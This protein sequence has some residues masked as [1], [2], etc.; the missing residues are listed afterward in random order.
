M[1]LRI[2]A[3]ST[4]RYIVD[5][6]W[7]GA[8]ERFV[9]QNDVRA[10]I[11]FSLRDVRGHLWSSDSLVDR[12]TLLVFTSPHCQPCKAIYP[13]LRA[14]R[15][16]GGVDLVLLSRGAARTNRAL[17]EEHALEG[18]TVLGS[19]KHVEEQLGV[20]GTPWV[21]LIGPGG[22]VLYG[23]PAR[24]EVLRMLAEAARHRVTNAGSA[25]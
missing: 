17:I 5:S 11:P 6:F 3:S 22:R 19:R 18:L 25:R 10:L 7:T 9:R 24:R 12:P 2:R 1:A 4:F 21:L 8:Y 20:K 14:L 23:G 15:D 16:G 13:G